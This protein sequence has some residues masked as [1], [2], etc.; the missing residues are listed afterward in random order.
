MQDS[1]VPTKMAVPF[2]NGAGVGYIRPIPT[3][4][5]IGLTPGAAS[6]TDGFPPLTFTPET[7]GGVPPSG[8]DMNGILN[9][10][11]AWV[12]WQAA[13]GP[14]YYDATFAVA[15]GGYPKGALLSNAS[16]PGSIWVCTLDNNATN[17]DTGGAGWIPLTTGA[18]PSGGNAF[19][20]PTNNDPV[21]YFMGQ[22]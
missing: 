11:S 15:I 10:L 14:N 17:P 20:I 4:S 13:G 2:A 18:A 12:R 22:L 21:N 16:T 6:L 9:L 5:Q 8:L 7:A 1:N 19:I 3:P